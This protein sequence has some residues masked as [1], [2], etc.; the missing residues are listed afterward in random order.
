M[1]SDEKKL[2]KRIRDIQESE[3]KSFVGR[4]KKEYK[5]AKD[6]FKKVS[7]SEWGGKTGTVCCNNDS[8]CVPWKSSSIRANL[9]RS[10]C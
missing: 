6:Q 4:Q 8:N 10:S 5:T 9:S 7:P 1:Q 3:K 2:L